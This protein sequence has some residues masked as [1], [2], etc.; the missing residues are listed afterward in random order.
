MATDELLKN[1]TSL[2]QSQKNVDE[3]IDIG[4]DVLLNMQEQRRRLL[5]TEDRFSRARL[6]LTSSKETLDAIQHRIR[7]DK[8]LF[9]SGVISVVFVIYL[10]ISFFS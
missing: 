4:T 3:Y 5:Q 2:S 8:R 9:W 7:Q 6:F 10:L 1:R